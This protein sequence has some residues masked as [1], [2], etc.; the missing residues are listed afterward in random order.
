[1]SSKSSVSS[2]SRFENHSSRSETGVKRYSKKRT[3]FSNEVSSN[4]AK[5]HFPGQLAVFSGLGIHQF[6]LNPAVLHIGKIGYFSMIEGSFT[7]FTTVYKVL[8]LKKKLS[9]VLEQ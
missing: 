5:S 8:K 4:N 3:S 2:V 9:D 6:I 7:D 1:M